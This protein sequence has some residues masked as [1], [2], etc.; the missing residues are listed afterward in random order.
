MDYGAALSLISESDL[1]AK[2]DLIAA[3]KQQVSTVLEEKRLAV[4][5]NEELK[6]VV[7][8]I[9]EVSGATGE[10]EVERAK[11][12]TTKI[13]SL[14]DALASTTKQVEKLLS[15]KSTLEAAQSALLTKTTL[16]ELAAKTG[17]NLSV[18]AKLI[19]DTGA[20]ELEG[21]SVKIGGVQ[22]DDWIKST[23]VAP[24]APALIPA[25]PPQL[26]I[27]S[28]AKASDREAP[29]SLYDRIRPAP[30]KIGG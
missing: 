20:V 24:F 25:K 10:S 28:S 22:W 18:L 23:E 13:K 14:T 7:A 8:A 17:A 16:Q 15:E 30:P 12:A 2:G 5:R 4:A 11:D 19:V 26:P 3:I 1:E 21:D 9:S 27:L 29:T 6:A